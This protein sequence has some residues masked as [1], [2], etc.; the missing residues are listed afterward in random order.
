MSV[1][2]MIYF[3]AQGVRVSVSH[4]IWLKSAFSAVPVPLLISNFTLSLSL[5]LILLLSLSLSPSVSLPLSLCTSASSLIA[6]QL[7]LSLCPCLSSLSLPLSQCPCLS[8]L[9]LCLCLNVPVLPLPPY[10]SAFLLLSAFFSLPPLLIEGLW[11]VR[12]K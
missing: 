8:S 9:F 10:F 7:L 11:L 3:K 12:I 2:H 6:S 4:L 5:S 1:S